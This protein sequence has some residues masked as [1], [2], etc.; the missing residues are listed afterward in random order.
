MGRVINTEDL[1]DGMTEGLLVAKVF[2]DKGCFWIRGVDFFEAK[3]LVYLGLVLDSKKKG[4]AD[5]PGGVWV[6]EKAGEVLWD[7]GCCWNHS[8]P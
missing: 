1:A 4:L 3:G 2:L 8:T 7:W 5:E 6:C